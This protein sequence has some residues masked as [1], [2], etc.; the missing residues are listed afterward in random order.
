MVVVVNKKG[1]SQKQYKDLDFFVWEDQIRKRNFVKNEI[2]GQFAR[3]CQ[4]FMPNL[5]LIK[6]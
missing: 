5:G 6:L 2:I 1:F 3:L 4:T